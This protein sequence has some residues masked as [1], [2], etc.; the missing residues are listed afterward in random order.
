MCLC[1]EPLVKAGPIKTTSIAKG[2]P[3]THLPNHSEN[4]LLAEKSVAPRHTLP[5]CQHSSALMYKH[6]VA[7]PPC[8]AWC[9]D[10]M[11]RQDS[12]KMK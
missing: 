9:K 6:T 12:I 5:V 8:A 4:I 11:G 3:F 7:E 1:Y 10:C 2:L